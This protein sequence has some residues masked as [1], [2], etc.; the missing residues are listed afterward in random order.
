MVQVSKR[1]WQLGLLFIFLVAAFHITSIQNRYM[2]DDEEIAFRTTSRDLSHTVWYQATQDVHAPIWFSSFWLWQQFI[3]STEFMGRVYSVFATLLTLALV[4][5][6]GRTWFNSA[7]VG[8]FAIAILGVNAYF[9]TFGLEIRPYAVNMLLATLSMWCFYRWLKRRTLLTALIYGVTVALMLYQHYFLIFLVTAQVY[10][11]FV[12]RPNRQMLQQIVAAWLFAFL[13]WSPWFPVAMHQVKTLIS[14]ES[15]FGNA[16]GAAG[17]GS[18]T[19]PTTLPAVINLVNLITSGQPGLYLLLLLIGLAYY[20]RRANYWLALLWAIAVPIVALLINFAFAVYTPRYITYLTIGF[21]LV[22]ALGVA[23]FPRRIQWLVL[24]VIAAI[25][26]WSLPSQFS[27]R[28]IPYRDFYRQMAKDAQSGDVLYI[29]QGD[30]T[31]NVVLWQMAHYLPTDLTNT[32]TSNLDQARKARRIWFVTA[33]WFNADVRSNFAQL[34]P[35]YPVQK[36]L[37]DCNR[38]WCYLIQ[39][40]EAPPL[41]TPR[42]FGTDMP[43]WGVDVES[44]THSEVDVHLWW[45]V[46]Q[47]PIMNYSIGLHLLDSNGNLVS[48]VDGPINEYGKQM[49]DATAMQ[50]GHIYIDYRS[51]TLPAATTPGTY[52]LELIVYDW[53]TGK[54]LLLSDGSDRLLL[55]Q[56]NVP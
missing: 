27:P 51:L 23:V 48:Q 14:V 21:A 29:D 32:S 50:P 47:P 10:L 6:I 2:R 19:E 46:E 3:G 37:G 8:I 33:D 31:N 43:F 18:T 36:V 26:L 52:Q 7:S 22:I 24:F 13:L 40:M 30:M 4:Y 25:S 38:N 35:D 15:S 17:I 49:V 20:W 55:N 11:L 45:Q 16:R 12:G 41:K 28:R 44:V 42:I 9:F 1:G 53:Q 56:I 54:R 34:E 39:L 5:Q